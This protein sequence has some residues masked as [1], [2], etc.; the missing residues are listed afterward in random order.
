MF[1]YSRNAI[2]TLDCTAPLGL[3]VCLARGELTADS[4]IDLLHSEL[5][6]CHTSATVTTQLVI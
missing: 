1:V 3:S 2:I 4:N 6:H 5:G